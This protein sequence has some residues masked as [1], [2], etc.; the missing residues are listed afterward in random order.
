M[1]I[2]LLISHDKNQRRIITLKDG[3]VIDVDFEDLSSNAP[4][5]A[6]LDQIFWGRILDITPTHAFVKIAENEVGLLPLE[7]PFPKPNEGQEVLVQV[8]REAIPDK[9]T[10]HKGP[11][12]TQRIILAGRYCLFHPFQKKRVLSSKLKDIE[13]RNRLQKLISANEPITL[14]E[15]AGSATPEQIREEIC[16]LRKKFQ[17]T[18]TLP[19]KVP[20]LLYDTLSPYQR[21]MRDMEPSEG[22]LILVDHDQTLVDIRHFLKNYRPDLLTLTKKHKGSLLKDFGLEDIWDSLFHERVDLPTGGN[23]VIEMTTAC[24]AIDVNRGGRST[25]TQQETNLA[26]IPIIIQHLKWRH[27]GGNI[28]IDFMGLESNSQNCKILEKQLLH[29]AALY[30]LSLDIFGWSKL[31]WLEARLPK[32]RRSLPNMTQTT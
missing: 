19:A 4:T 2:Q 3:H 5:F 12:L 10:Y 20:S 22:N 30:D 23:I 14:R 17:D 25:Y 1:P 9:G 7:H 26:A 11:L 27:L 31:G 18:E 32:Q 16:T 29:Q 6:Q 24:I 13:I 8:R 15:A 21:W 28:I